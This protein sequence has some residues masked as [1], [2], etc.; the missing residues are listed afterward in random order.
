MTSDKTAF[1]HIIEENQGIIFKVCRMYCTN[2]DDIEDLFQEIALQLWKSYPT[3][4]NDAKVSTWIY[5]IALN[6]TISGLRKKGKSRIAFQQLSAIHHN[7][8]ENVPKR[9]DMEWD[10]ELQAAINTLNKFDKSLLMLYLDEKSYKEM[11]E[12]LEISENSVG[13]KINRIK[14]KL[15]EKLNPHTHGT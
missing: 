5:R 6:T 9:I 4:R 7:L 8:P 10:H 3:F 13:V 15:K 12:I 2:Q 14:K 11:A 1:V